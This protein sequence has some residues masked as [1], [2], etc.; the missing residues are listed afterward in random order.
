MYNNQ[1]AGPAF[2]EFL[3]TIGT[4]CFLLQL[5][6]SHIEAIVQDT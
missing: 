3:D 6:L 5:L 2:L 4:Q 1:H